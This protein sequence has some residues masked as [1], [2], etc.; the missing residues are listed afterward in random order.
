MRL[1]PGVLVLAILGGSGCFDRAYCGMAWETET[2][3]AQPAVFETFPA[4]EAELE[5][6]SVWWTHEHEYEPEGG[7]VKGQPP[8]TPPPGFD[9]GNV[10][11]KDAMGETGTWRTHLTAT[12]EGNVT[13]Q[14]NA[15]EAKSE[16][17]T[18]DRLRSTFADLA[19]PDPLA[20]TTP[21]VWQ[22]FC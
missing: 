15:Y 21:F 4:D 2:S 6:Y 18:R 17:W 8:P 13:W 16:G 20:T 10:T 3:W 22:K 14:V 7:P 5:R 1:L 12:P 9:P 11:R 19:L